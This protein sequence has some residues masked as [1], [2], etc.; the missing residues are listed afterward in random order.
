M[1]SVTPTKTNTHLS[2]HDVPVLMDVLVEKRLKLKSNRPNQTASLNSQL[3]NQLRELRKKNATLQ[4]KNQQAQ[5]YAERVQADRDEFRKQVI[6]LLQRSKLLEQQLE[7]RHKSTW[8]EKLSLELIKNKTS[9]IKVIKSHCTTLLKTTYTIVLQTTNQIK[10]LIEKR[11]THR[12]ESHSNISN[13]KTRKVLDKRH[14]Q[15]KKEIKNR[16]QI[17]EKN[18][19]KKVIKH[20]YIEI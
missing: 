17:I 10:T 9:K 13:K 6:R 4:M 12:L 15:N 18:A 7:D 8:N 11:N 16:R 20:D 5:R 3:T 19:V 2:T 14:S 1:K